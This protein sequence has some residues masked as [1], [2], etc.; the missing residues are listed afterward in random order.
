VFI[1]EGRSLLYLTRSLVAGSVRRASAAAHVSSQAGAVAVDAGAAESVLVAQ[2]GAAGP[3]AD[4]TGVI[5]LEAIKAR[6]MDA[7]RSQR[8]ASNR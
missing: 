6:N 2:G 5:D 1:G 3:A 7:K 4:A 8:R